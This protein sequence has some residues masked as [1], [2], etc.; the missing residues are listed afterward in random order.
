[1]H[2]RVAVVVNVRHVIILIGLASSLLLAGLGLLPPM[3]LLVTVFGA[4]RTRPTHL[5][6][7]QFHMKYAATERLAANKSFH[8]IKYFLANP[9]ATQP[10]LDRVRLTGVAAL[11]LSR[12]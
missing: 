5:T 6:R 11:L 4:T 3:L 1:M 10:T 8:Q 12:F 2:S 7:V 9:H